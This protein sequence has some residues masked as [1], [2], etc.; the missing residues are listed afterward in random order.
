MNAAVE[1]RVPNPAA[2][3]CFIAATF[4]AFHEQLPVWNVDETPLYV[5]TRGGKQGVVTGDGRVVVPFDWEEIGEFDDHGMAVA[6]KERPPDPDDLSRDYR[7]GMVGIIDRCGRVIIPLER[8]KLGFRVLRFD[9]HEQY[10]VKSNTRLL[11]YNRSGRQ[12]MKAE[13][14]PLSDLQFDSHGLLA[15]RHG[16]DVGWINRE[17]VLKVGAPEGLTPVSNFQT[18]G[19]AVVED[20]L[21]RQGCVDL[22]GRIVIDAEWTDIDADGS[23]YYNNDGEFIRAENYILAKKHLPLEPWQPDR[24]ACFFRNGATIIPDEYTSISL[25]IEEAIAFVTGEDGK[26]GVVDFSNRVLI[27]QQYDDLSAFCDQGLAAAKKNGKR[28]WINL[29]GETIIPFEYSDFLPFNKYGL[30]IVERDHLWGGH[31]SRWQSRDTL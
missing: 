21:E 13:W 30:A 5:A 26:W 10:L 29:R 25:D 23:W 14:E 4:Y 3:I 20:S 22:T 8:T 31:Q 28:G 19:L 24:A 2:T 16:D 15:A 1:S 7:D 9:D 11:I 6:I 17:G 18:N 27:P 12:L